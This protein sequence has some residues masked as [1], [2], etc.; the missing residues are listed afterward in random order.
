MSEDDDGSERG[1]SLGGASIVFGGLVFVTYLL[2]ALRLGDLYPLSDFTMFAEPISTPSRVMARLGDGEVVEVTDLVGW[3][4]PADLGMEPDGPA[5]Y[6]LSR[7]VDQMVAGYIR[8]NPKTGE[9]GSPVTL[10]R[11]VFQVTGDGVEVLG[12]LPLSR[13]TASRAG[14]T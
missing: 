11:R 9:T 10:V 3:V 12:D 8:D 13:C 14:D 4:C 5:P 6:F 7:D 1:V 2:L